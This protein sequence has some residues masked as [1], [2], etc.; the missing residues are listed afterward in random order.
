[1]KPEAFPHSDTAA[2]KNCG[3]T[4]SGNFCHQCGQATHLHVPSAF[5]FLHEFVSH[6]V[7]LEGKL[8]KSLKLLLFKPGMLTR[9]YIEGRRARYL[10]PLRL[11]LSFSIIFFALFKFGGLEFNVMKTD[12][13]ELKQAVVHTPTGESVRRPATPEELAQV[14]KNEKEVIDAASLVGPALGHA[15]KRLLNQSEQERNEM[16]KRAFFGNAPYAVF[17]LMPVFA[18]FLKIL[19]LG[20]GRTYGEHFLFALHTNAFAFFMLG[21]LILVPE[22]WGLVSFGLFIWLTFYLPTAMRRVYGG[23][24]VTTALRWLVLMAV[25]LLSIVLAVIV[26][27]GLALLG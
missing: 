10:E 6:Y 23:G 16:L 21:L 19:Y 13:D 5:E 12:R 1:M 17:A 11:Y 20:K 25:H 9:E 7:A 15:A 18:L 24:R 3:A 27:V 2:C 22:G 4:T 8:W 26:A 14:E